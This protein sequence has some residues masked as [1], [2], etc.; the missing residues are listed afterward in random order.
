MDQEKSAMSIKMMYLRGFTIVL[1]WIVTWPHVTTNTCIFHTSHYRKAPNTSVIESFGVTNY[2]S[3]CEFLCYTH[4]IQCV[5]ANIVLQD[6]GSYLCQF[7]SIA[8]QTEY[9]F[10]L[11]PNPNGKYISRYSGMV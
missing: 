2:Q 5:A 4:P 1:L 6:D 7:V 10:L 3:D 11:E 8:V 9:E